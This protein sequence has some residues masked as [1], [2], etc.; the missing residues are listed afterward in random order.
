MH[1]R[2]SPFLELIGPLWSR[3]GE[4][5]LEFALTIDDRHVNG[6]GLAHGGVLAGLA[7]VA[8]GYA[9]ASSVQP[10]AQLIT[11][12]LTVDFVGVATRG[13]VVVSTTDVQ[14]VGGRLAFANCYLSV[15]DKR[16]VRASAVFANVGNC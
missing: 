16:I 9:S 13:D 12:N 14:K 15:A 7:D 11:A 10:P 3:E 4:H 1:D 2:T 8:L 5:G 6:R